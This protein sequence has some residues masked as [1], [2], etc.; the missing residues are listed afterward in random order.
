MRTAVVAFYSRIFTVA[1]SMVQSV[2]CHPPLPL[3]PLPLPLPPSPSTSTPSLSTSTPSLSLHLHS[4][5][6]LPLP[7]AGTPVKDVE[8]PDNPARKTLL[9]DKH[10]DYIEAFERDKDDFVCTWESVYD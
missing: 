3:L 7:Q 2:A 6:P 4:L 9:L 8:L 10:A 5:S 1:S